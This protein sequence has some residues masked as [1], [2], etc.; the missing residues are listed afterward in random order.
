MNR[1]PS[2]N[3]NQTEH[4]NPSSPKELIRVAVLGS[5][6][7]IGTQTLDTIA[8]LN[9][10]H[11]QGRC[12]SRYE[13]VALA[14]GSNT[15]A[16][17]AQARAHPNA[18]IGLSNPNTEPN[19]G[20]DT[21]QSKLNPN[22]LISA[23][24]APTQL[25]ERTNPDLVVAA[26]VGIAGLPSTLRA[27][28]LGI[29]IALANKESL[30]AAG[31]LVTK[32]ANNSGSAILPVDS[33]HAG[34]WECLLAHTDQ[35]PPYT[36]I[37]R[38]IERVT[39]TASG[40]PFRTRTLEQIHSATPD[41]AL[42]HPTWSMGAKVSIDSATLMN[43]ALELIE[44]RWLFALN[45]DQLDAV[46]HPQSTVHALVQ[47]NDASVLAHMGP[48]DMRC[49]IQNALT[50]PHRSQ[51][52]SQPLDLA[53]MGPLDFEPINP[54]RFPAIP[55]AKS[56]IA[57]QTHSSPGAVLNAANEAA[58]SAFLNEQIPFGH[59]IPVIKHTLEQ[60][61]HSNLDSLDAVMDAHAKARAAA[62]SFISTHTS[63]SL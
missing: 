30:V 26:I 55:I 25:I 3:M 17:A 23:P 62:Q 36:S 12:P 5:T 44:A 49:P 10:L 48:T 39:L 43:K 34:L 59:I 58:V 28:Q 56:V 14:A 50:Y 6:G 63:Q 2:T 31:H 21:D 7:S 32:A 4:I 52:Q 37:P 41:Q 8:H 53:N 18:L 54:K 51:S 57:N 1:T 15:N 35:L 27:A 22:S 9:A 42:K 60:F 11:E 29:N 33:E 38:T 45:A 13:V 20:P 46:I 40:G 47:T 24:D 61:N 19:T 16:I